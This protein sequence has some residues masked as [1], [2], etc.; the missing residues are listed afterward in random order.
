MGTCPPLNFEPTIGGVT[1]LHRRW[2]QSV[3]PQRA[4]SAR[5][6]LLSSEDVVS[7]DSA[8]LQFGDKN[9]EDVRLFRVKALHLNHAV[10]TGESVPVAK[11]TGRRLE[12]G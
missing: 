1:T 12:R 5:R 10:L 6:A 2:A 3:Q 9:F 11:S 8:I 7:A 4:R